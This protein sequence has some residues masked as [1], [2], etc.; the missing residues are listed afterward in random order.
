MAIQP[1][2]VANFNLIQFATIYNDFISSQPKE[3]E[4]E[5]I[6]ANFNKSIIKIQNVGMI[7]DILSTDLAAETQARID[8]D[9]QIKQ[10][11]LDTSSTLTSKID[12]EIQAREMADDAI[13]TKLSE[14]DAKV[15]ENTQNITITQQ[16][17]TS[18]DQTLTE[19]INREISDRTEA[20]IALDKKYYDITE[21]EKAARIEEDSKLD[22]K[23][24]EVDDR[25][26]S[27]ITQETQD[28]IDA[29][30]SL[31]ETLMNEITLQ[32]STEKTRAQTA[33]GDLDFNEDI[34]DANGE[35]ATNLTDAINIVD[36]RVQAIVEGSSVDLDSLKEIVDYI[37]AVDL[38]N[39]NELAAFITSVTKI[40]G[41]SGEYTPFVDAKY[42]AEATS[43]YDAD[44]KLDAAITE[45]SDS[46]DSRII[47][48]QT[49]DEE[50]IS[51]IE[52]DEAKISANETEIDATKL[53]LTS[54]IQRAQAVE[55]T[56]KLDLTTEAERAKAA[57]GDLEFDEGIKNE[58][59]STPDNLT[60]AINDVY[61]ECRLNTQDVIAYLETIF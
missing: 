59:G 47:E 56:I 9:N 30:A 8:A 45:L 34:R 60:D 41:L 4:V 33:E 6:D 21:A 7:K 19:K 3:L 18:L 37:N 23:I 13:L 44:K 14:T 29:D 40:T 17:L 38:Q 46:T 16:N 49:K 10:D 50:I 54:E 31:K 53:N 58:D 12:S 52:E 27:A 42:I 1:Y 43:L 48:L 20:D 24:V 2:E 22:A 61:R 36:N 32:V 25:L 55:E 11:L 26:T 57:E 28:R 35:K 51:R 39:D 5:Y 15:A